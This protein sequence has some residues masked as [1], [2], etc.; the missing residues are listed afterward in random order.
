MRP[1]GDKGLRNTYGRAEETRHEVIF[2]SVGAA[3]DDHASGGHSA[4]KAQI[5][6]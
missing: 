1:A 2:R 4:E 3:C 5:W 6:L